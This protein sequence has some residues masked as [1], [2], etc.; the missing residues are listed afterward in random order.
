MNLLLRTAPLVSRLKSLN[1]RAR[2]PRLSAPSPCNLSPYIDATGRPLIWVAPA[3][4]ADRRDSGSPWEQRPGD[5]H[6]L[7]GRFQAKKVVGIGCEE[8]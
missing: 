7:E 5:C 2:F 1:G 4:G 3:D 8:R 6:N